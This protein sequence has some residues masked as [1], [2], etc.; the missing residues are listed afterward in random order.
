MQLRAYTEA[1]LI[2]MISKI[3]TRFSKIEMPSVYDHHLQK[4]NGK[5]ASI[6]YIP[7]VIANF[8]KNVTL[9]TK[10]TVGPSQPEIIHLT[11]T[12]HIEQVHDVDKSTFDSVKKLSDSSN[13]IF[14]GTVQSISLWS[15]VITEVNFD[16]IQNH[17]KNA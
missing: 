12:F 1:G 10:Q 4:L 15:P 13:F 3:S 14:P 6:A 5:P 16:M 11:T 17:L 8:N 7:N 9:E 2:P